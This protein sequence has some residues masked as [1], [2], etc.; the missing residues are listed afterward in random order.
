M[1]P[2]S[3]L[4]SVQLDKADLISYDN[5]VEIEHTQAEGPGDYVSVTKAA[6]A[7]VPEE[8][9]PAPAQPPQPDSD[10]DSSG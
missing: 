2:K 9:P 7:P 4:L 10:S 3:N 1:F 6:P 5:R 8:P